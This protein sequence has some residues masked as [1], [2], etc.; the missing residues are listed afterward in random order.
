MEKSIDE[1]LQI[2]WEKDKNFSLSYGASNCH[3]SVFHSKREDC[4]TCGFG[5]TKYEEKT[6]GTGDN[7]KEA[8]YNLYKQLITDRKITP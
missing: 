5:I 7:P 2:I 6:I 3:A 4:P 1:I 8:I